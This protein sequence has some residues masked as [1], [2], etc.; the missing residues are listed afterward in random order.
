LIQAG[1][2]PTAA[3]T[4]VA[5]NADWF[6]ILQQDSP[7]LL[8]K[9][10]YLLQNLGKYPQWMP[11]IENHPETAA[12]L[13]LADTPA[14]LTKSLTNDDCY[15]FITGMFV[16][17]AARDEAIAL[18]QALDTN[19]NLICRLARRGLIGSQ[20]LFLFPH[21]N[22]GAAEYERWLAEVLNDGLSQSDEQLS[23]LLNFLFEQGASLR[24]KMIDNESFRYTFRQELWP[25]FMRVVNHGQQPFEFYVNDSH[26]WDLLALREGEALLNKWG[27][28]SGLGYSPAD[29]LFGN[30]AYPKSLHPAFIEAVLNDDENTLVALLEWGRELR[31][32][33]LFFRLPP[34]LRPKLYE[35]L[36]N[37]KANYPSELEYYTGLSDSALND[38]LNPK[39]G[40]LLS[41][42]PGY[43][44]LS[45]IGKFAQGR[46]VSGG[47][48]AFATADMGDLA[49]TI[50]TLGAATTLTTAAKQGLKSTAKAAVKTTARQLMEKQLG[51]KVVAKASEQSL[52]SWVKHDLFTKLQQLAKAHLVEPQNF[53]IT[54]VTQFL[55]KKANP[56]LNRQSFKAVG[57]EP[58]LF[59][60]RDATVVIRFQQ[61]HLKDSLQLV[62]QFFANS[63]NQATGAELEQLGEEAESMV[64]TGFRP[65]DQTAWQK[66]VSA[67]WLMNASGME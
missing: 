13:T 37:A 26:L 55:F 34:D 35:G 16:Q 4:V 40:G 9:Q 3:E 44:T 6:Q 50:F 58:R 31:F 14:R 39:P 21:N 15:N 12:L 57:L 38:E 18:A 49:V 47:D 8:E 52:N 59:M 28:K 11:W 30:E 45:V 10:R 33:R 60:R 54:P 17:H 32:Q 24:G 22:P 19:K 23:S 46:R 48:L 51:E 61:S 20:A 36:A 29:V 65:P 56:V 64:V 43:D 25:K 53:N 27:V 7:Q 66:N 5:L 41:N 63:A 62:S 67:W 2:T 42:V 1:W